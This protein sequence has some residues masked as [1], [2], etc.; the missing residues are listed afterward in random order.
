[1]ALQTLR[2]YLQPNKFGRSETVDSSHSQWVSYLSKIILLALLYYLLGKL[3]FAITTE[4]VIVALAVFTPEGISLAA[5]ILL[6]RCLWPGIFLGQ[7]ILAFST[8]IDFFP[9]LSL[10]II[11]SGQAVLGATLF[12]YFKLNKAIPNIKD[13]FGLLAITAFIIQPI[14][15]V[16]G[17]ITLLLASVIDENNLPKSILSWWFANIMGQFL[18]TPMI[19]LVYAHWEELEKRELFLLCWLFFLI[20]Y[21]LL[22]ILPIQSLALIISLTMPLMILVSALRGATHAMIITTINAFM[23]LFATFFGVGAFSGGDIVTD[24]ADLSFYILSHIL[25]LLTI[26]TLI[27]ELKESEQRLKAMALYDPL[28][29]L[30]NRNL[31]EERMNHAIAV[32]HRYT[33]KSAICFIDIDEFKIINDTYGHDTGDKVINIVAKRIKECIQEDDSLIRLGGDEFLLIAM[34]MQTIQTI[35]TLLQ[36][37]TLSVNT[38]MQINSN[39]VKISL[40]TG[41]AICPDNGDS[42]TKLISYA[43]IAMYQAKHKGKNQYTFYKE[44][45]NTE[46]VNV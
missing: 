8:G 14:S 33:M 22:F 12:H 43:D 13:V 29:G 41:V 10:G 38:P 20:D 39:I 24:I 45:S 46:K 27:G 35:N 31:L 26:G 19:L 32:A 21:T 44:P 28:T 6:G 25:I 40:S 36:R 17:N 16:L 1:M 34:D 37:I 11:N 9:A 5:L 2:V 23:A 7:F 15:A 18:V 3:S 30:P 42:T 4:N